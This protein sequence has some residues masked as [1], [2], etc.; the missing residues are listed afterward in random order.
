MFGKIYQIIRRSISCLLIS[1]FFISVVCGQ[2]ASGNLIHEQGPDGVLNFLQQNEKKFLTFTSLDENELD[3]ATMTRHLYRESK[4]RRHMR[5]RT[6]ENK[7]VKSL[8]HF[9][10][11]TLV[12]VTSSTSQNW[13]KYYYL[14]RRL[15]SR[16]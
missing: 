13:K 6:L 16:K 11:D 8:H 15:V 3:V 14:H 4:L 12:I 9:E 5:S 2:E 1:V 10:Q 7:D